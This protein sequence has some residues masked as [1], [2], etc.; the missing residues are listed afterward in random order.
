VRVAAY[1]D[2]VYRREGGAIYAERAFALFLARVGEE[3]DELVV[4]GRL[5]PQAGRWHYR[6]PG[7][8][9]FV[10]L[11]HYARL[12]QPLPVLLAM[13]RSA[14]AFWRVLDGVDAVWLFGPHPLAFAFAALAAVRGRG[15]V[16]AVRQDLP[17]YTAQRH[18]AR[19]GL[20]LAALVLEHAFRALG[21]TCRVVA[22][23]P[24]LARH[25]RNA[26]EVL[27][28]GVPLVRESD[29]VPA[30][31]ASRRSYEGPLQVLS[32]GR[33]DSEKNPL[34][35]A[36]VLADLRAR[37]P[38]WRLVVCGDGPLRD[39]L[40]E[41]LAALGVAEHADLRGYV[42]LDGGLLDLYRESH[43]FLHVSWT[44][45]LPQVL[46]EAFA[47]RVPVV[48]TAVGGGREAAGDA[49]LLVPPGDARAAAD[50]LR[51]VAGDGALRS[52]LAEAGVERVRTRTLDAEA[53]RVAGF[54]RSAVA[55]GG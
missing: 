54:L 27:E 20:R 7:A 47:C 41:R 55:R 15:V 16:L 44:E 37:E 1:T 2:Y 6:L 32:V 13:A 38:R 40:A 35:L 49:A 18:P 42:P 3:L 50:A 52:R 31:D 33:L 10:A 25:Y 23:G 34:L 36:D 46:F 19:R 11:P 26:G 48:A 22:V 17:R 8:I 24:E 29:V 5:E 53:R 14:R 4:V 43:A 39:E 51:R 9:R 21:R 28:I 30:A 45:G 12:S